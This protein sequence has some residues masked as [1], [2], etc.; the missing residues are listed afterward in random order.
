MI[1]IAAFLVGVTGGALRARSRQGNRLDMAQ[2]AATYG[3]IFA[4][5][6]VFITVALGRTI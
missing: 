5:I 1:V 2:Y 3:I 6:G 4:I